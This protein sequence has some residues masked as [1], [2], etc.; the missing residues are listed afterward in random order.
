MA[1]S[2]EIRRMSRVTPDLGE[3][4]GRLLPQ[5]APGL[6]APEA[7]RLRAMVG[8]ERTALFAA[9]DD[10]RIVG[11]LALVWYD[12]PSG[13]KA[14][15]E[16]VVV[17]ARER[18]RGAGRMLVEAALAHAR[19]VGARSVS[20]TSNP[21]RVAAHALYRKCGFEEVETTLF[22]FDLNKVAL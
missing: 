15:V 12:V 7:G 9:V 6:A 14:W 20:L 5:L 16:D 3:A 8:D 10:G 11:L 21:A 2:L 1:M 19:S 17:D 18:S 22:R 4:F 13:R